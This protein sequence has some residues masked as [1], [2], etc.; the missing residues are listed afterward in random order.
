MS[1]SF[2][3]FFIQSA[4]GSAKSEALE[5][6]KKQE[7]PK[8]IQKRENMKDRNLYYSQS[9]IDSNTRHCVERLKESNTS[10]STEFRLEELN[11]HLHKFPLAAILANK[12]GAQPLVHSLFKQNKEN[13]SLQGLCKEI[14]GRL[15]YQEQLSTSPGL[16]ILSIDGGG[17]KGVMALEILR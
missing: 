17:M 16:R 6:A 13:E 1:L 11:S 3:F 7:L 5:S 8:F 4:N 14:L 10:L 12:L 15:G 9:A 2:F